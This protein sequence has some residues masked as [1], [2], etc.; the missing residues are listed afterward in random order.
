MLLSEFTKHLETLTEVNFQKHDGT[1]VP[2][3]FHITEVGQIT[4]K[5]IDCGGTIRNENVISMQLWES[6]DFWHRLE[7]A[8]LISIIK[9]SQEKLGIEDHEIEIEYQSDTI[10]KYGVEFENGIFVLTT[11][12]TDCLASDQCGIPTAKI[13]KNLSEL[14][15][16]VESCCSPGGGCC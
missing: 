9:L 1:E 12:K 7:P 4:K 6:I 14:G 13:K 15:Q 2:K 16:K 8:K 3:H 10:G 11:K 5:F